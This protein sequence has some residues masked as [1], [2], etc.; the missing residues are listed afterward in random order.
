MEFLIPPS[1]HFGRQR[2]L[3]LIYSLLAL[4]AV[5]LATIALIRSVSTGAMVA[6]NLAF[7][8]EAAA[9]SDQVAR[10][11]VNWMSAKLSADAT[12]LGADVASSGYYASYDTFNGPID[13]TGAQSKVNTRKLVKWDN[14]YCGLQ[15][16]YASCAFT[17]VSVASINGNEASYIIF[18]MCDRGG[19]PVSD[20][21]INCARP[22]TV[23]SVSGTNEA[24][25]YNV[26]SGSSTVTSSPYYRIIVRVVGGRNTVSFTET[27]VHF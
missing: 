20:T 18:R 27:I 7:Q 9:T 3:S 8:Q 19:N 17:P 5:S 10:Q 22:L 25:D 15:S 4:A 11:A 24:R 23:S 21:T 13:V 1:S 2:G 14:D 6:G 12:S 26:G 16:G